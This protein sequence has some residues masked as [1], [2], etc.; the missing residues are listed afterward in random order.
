MSSKL[1]RQNKIKRILSD[2]IISNQEQILKLLK[3]EGVT[4]TQATL[5][6]DFAD[7]GVIRTFTPLGVQYVISS[8]DYGKEIAKLVGLEILNV[9]HNGNLIVLRTLAGR[10][11]GVAHY[12]DRMNKEEI[13]GTI[14]GDDTVLIIPNNVNNIEKVLDILKDL[15]TDNYKK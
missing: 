4:I 5:S 10:A 2:R 11:Q 1:V 7:L 15:I 6:R 12:I 14:G 13:L 9:A 3:N 8:T